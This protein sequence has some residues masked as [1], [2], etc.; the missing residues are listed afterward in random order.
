[1]KH[2]IN[3]ENTINGEEDELNYAFKQTAEPRKNVE[4]F[5]SYKFIVKVFDT[6]G[7]GF[8]YD[9]KYASECVL[10][11]QTSLKVNNVSNNIDAKDHLGKCINSLQIY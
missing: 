6:K 11:L 5:R 9:N 2:R 10:G 1:M 8:E 4:R 3:C 7:P